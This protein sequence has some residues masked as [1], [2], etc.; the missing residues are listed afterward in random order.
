MAFRS[1]KIT[2]D[3]VLQ[4][5]G[6]S[7]H[8]TLISRAIHHSAVIQNKV[9]DKTHSIKKAQDGEF[10][11]YEIEGLKPREDTKRFSRK[12]KKVPIVRFRSMPVDQDWTN[13]WP[14]AAT[15][16]WSAVPF[17]VRQGFIKN[18]A[19]NEGIVPSSY[20][21][22]ELM[23]PPNFLHLTPAHIK[24]QCAALKKFCTE[25]PEGLETDDKC[26]QHFPIEMISSDYVFSSPSIAD[27]RAR[28]ACLQIHLSDLDLDYHA[29][30]KFIRLVG[31]RYD[32][33]TDIVKFESDRCP[34][35]TQNLEYL[36]FLLT[37]VYFESWKREGWEDLKTLQDMEKYVWEINKS[38]ENLISL[39]KNIQTIDEKS[40]E[41]E[42]RLDYL[43]SEEINNNNIGELPEVQTYKTAVE[44]LFNE[45]ENIETINNYKNSV[46]KLLNLV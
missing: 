16:K 15:F 24:K 36:K 46:K 34:L 42:K 26:R 45:G 27:E 6:F 13:V 19:E 33:D 7:K 18:S 31:D 3:L 23:K 14:T 30:D 40:T 38:H 10:R 8:P 22:L 12:L 21:N 39:L 5:N 35:K 41:E 9:D 32:P 2:T 20:G 11:V 25:W 4:F 37:A 29:K 43:P 17:P 44:E 1:V 28:L